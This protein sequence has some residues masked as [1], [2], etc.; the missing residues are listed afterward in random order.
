MVIV[1]Q[2]ICYRTAFEF[3]HSTKYSPSNTA[4]STIDL[5]QQTFFRFPFYTCS[6]LLFLLTLLKV[7]NG[8]S[9]KCAYMLYTQLANVWY[10]FNCGLLSVYYPFSDLLVLWCHLYTFTS[11][12]YCAQI[13]ERIKMKFCTHVVTVIC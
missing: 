2:K 7:M 6:F 3:L 4:S 10:G 5:C 13:N 12:E 11:F 8:M 1:V 9:Q